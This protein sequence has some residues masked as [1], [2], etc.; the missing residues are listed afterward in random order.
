M[1]KESDFKIKKALVLSVE[2]TFS[3]MA[4]IDAGRVEENLEELDFSHI[5]HI[6]LFAPMQVEIAL[7]L[8]SE[9]KKL[10]VENIYG[11]DWST[12]HATEIDD[13][14]LEMLNVLAGNFLI[15]CFG[16]QVKYDISLPE[17][18]FDDSKISKRNGFDF[19]PF[20][21]EGIPFKAAIKIGKGRYGRNQK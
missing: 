14:L 6:D 1:R 13:C 5:I 18:L 11:T 21:A 2:K 20:D 7:F 17:L 15:E 8:P 10:I 3:D 12:L 16:R 4:F 9:C 19:F